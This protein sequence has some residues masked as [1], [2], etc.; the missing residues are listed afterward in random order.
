MEAAPTLP[1]A[2]LDDCLTVADLARRYRV[3]RATIWR[4]VE[5]EV[6]PAP[7]Y[8]GARSPRWFAAEVDAAFRARRMSPRAAMEMRRRGLG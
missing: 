3:H 8:I 2:A 5:R 1:T 6:L 4:L 7:V